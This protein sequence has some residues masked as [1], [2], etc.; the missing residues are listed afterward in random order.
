MPGFFVPGF[1]APRLFMPG[2]FVPRFF[3]ARLG[4]HRLGVRLPLPLRLE[5]VDAALRLDHGRIDVRRHLVGA[6]TAVAIAAASAAAAPALLVAALGALATLWA[7]V[8][9]VDARLRGERGLRRLQGLRFGA[10]HDRVR[11]RRL[12]V[13]LL[14]L[15]ALLLPLLMLRALSL[16]LT[17][18][19]GPRTAIRPA[20]V[21]LAFVPLTVARTAVA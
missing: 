20:I 11:L 12:R 4:V 10:F 2:L 15:G 16:L 17:T 6:R 18:V 3:M 13:L 14:R 7:R 1:F 21:T 9:G 5:L 19:V 8:A